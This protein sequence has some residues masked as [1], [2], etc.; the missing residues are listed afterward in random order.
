M[1]K[2]GVHSLLWLLVFKKLLEDWPH[3]IFLTTPPVHI[4]CTFYAYKVHGRFYTEAGLTRHLEP[5]TCFCTWNVTFI[6]PFI[7]KE[8]N[9]DSWWDIASNKCCMF[10]PF[11]WRLFLTGNKVDWYAQDIFIYFRKVKTK[12]DESHLGIYCSLYNL[13]KKLALWL[14]VSS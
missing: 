7:S 6:S 3:F 2:T 12:Y 9:S 10:K 8:A 11:R 13:T 1:D 5:T 14:Q 4:N